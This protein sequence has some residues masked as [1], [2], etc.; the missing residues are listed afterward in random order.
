MSVPPEIEAQVLAMLV[1]V[2]DIIGIAN[3]YD[4]VYVRTTTPGYSAPDGLSFASSASLI[5]VHR[6]VEGTIPWS[7]LVKFIAAGTLNE[8]LARLS[9]VPAGTSVHPIYAEVIDDVRRR[10]TLAWEPQ[11][12]LFGE[13]T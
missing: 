9:E 3:G 12:S 5:R 6:P 4:D 11:L 2:T 7:R 1:T 13:P 10:A 8:H